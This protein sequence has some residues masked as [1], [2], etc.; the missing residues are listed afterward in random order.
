MR[1]LTSM[2]VAGAIAIGAVSPSFAATDIVYLKFKDGTG[3]TWKNVPQ[4]ISNE[5]FA[6]F[7][8]RD[9]GKNFFT[10]V[11][12]TQSKV[13]EEEAPKSDEKFC[14]NTFCKVA[15]G[16]GAILVVGALLSSISPA[17]AAAGSCVLPSDIAKDGSRCGGRASSVRPGGR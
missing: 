10:D 7:V 11:D 14:S 12:H 15:V 1:K 9:T 17:A 8:R 6:E 3:A 5:E 4:T 16:I 2:I 13:V